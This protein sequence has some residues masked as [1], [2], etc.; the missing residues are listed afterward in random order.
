[1]TDSEVRDRK[2]PGKIQ[3]NPNRAAFGAPGRQPDGNAG[4]NRTSS[5]G[6][7][8]TSNA[9]RRQR[10]VWGRRVNSWDHHAPSGLEKVT[11]A[12]IAAA[13]ARP[14]DRIVDLGCGTGQLSLPLAEC[15]AQVLAVD[16]SP[17]MVDR[18]RAN[19]RDRGLPGIEALALPIENLSL[20][21]GRVDLVVTSYAFHH[22]RDADKS[23]VVSAAS[24]WLRPGG[25]LIVADMMFGRGGTSQDRAIIKSKVSALARKGIG[26]WWRIAK[27]SYRY[28][29]RAQERPVSVAAWTS[30]F[31]AA[32]LTGVTA[33]PVVAEASMVIGER[34]A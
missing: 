34:P 31:T 33:T 11:A 7:L 15:G 19:A 27:N 12:V 22:L 30:M 13:G 25:R 32:G 8:A 18:L 10:K 3:A 28:L 24:Q 6:R 23:R 9:V 29:V 1:M 20:P 21:P 16:V 2:N 17:Q 14:G 4:N 5:L 26:G